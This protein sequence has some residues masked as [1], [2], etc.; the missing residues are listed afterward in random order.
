M[1]D[2]EE[3]KRISKSGERNEERI[4]WR[5]TEKRERKERKRAKRRKMVW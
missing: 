2:T 3:R 5:N 1:R 4:N